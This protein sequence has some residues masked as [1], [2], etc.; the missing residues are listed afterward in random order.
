MHPD[1]IWLTVYKEHVPIQGYLADK[2]LATLSTMQH[3]SL[4]IMDTFMPFQHGT[5]A[6]N[7]GTPVTPE[8]SF[9]IMN[10]INMV[11]QTSII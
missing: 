4:L 1:I 7:S 9:I 3:F 8:A 6:D 2:S 10:Y 5:I 11:S